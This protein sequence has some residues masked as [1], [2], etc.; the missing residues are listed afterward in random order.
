MSH[1]SS[2]KLIS[3]NV[4]RSKHLARNIPFLQYE[5]PDILSAQEVFEGDLEQISN[6]LSMPFRIWLRNTLV[7]EDKNMPGKGGYSGIAFFSRVPF[8]HFGHEYYHMPESGITQEKTSETY[9]ETNAN[10]II[11]VGIEKDEVEYVFVTTHFTWSVADYA[12]DNQRSDFVV[13]KNLLKKIG[14]HVFSG[15]LNAPRGGEMWDNFVSL[16]GQDNIPTEIH[17]TMD[18]DLHKCKNLQ[19][20][21]DGVFAQPPYQ[22][23]NVRVVSGVSDH[24]AIIASIARLEFE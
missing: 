2:L 19:L 23:S 16:Y 13:L 3:L 18:Q 20:V 17:T 22:V 12:N 15:D 10:G 5:K 9:H 8:S 24:Q 6:D 14:P 4:E 1:Q 11:W 21:V 7:G